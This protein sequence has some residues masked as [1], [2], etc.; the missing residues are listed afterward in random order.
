MIDKLHFIS[1]QNETINHLQSICKALMCGCKWVQ[2]RVKKEPENIIIDLA[3]EA[4]KLCD[5]FQAKLIINDYP[6][7][8]KEVSAH[9]VH[10][11]SEDMSIAEARKI[12]GKEFIIGGTSN[13]YEKIVEH[14]NNG[15]DYIGL[16]P[17]RFTK[18][19]ENLS[20]VL[21]TEGYRIII[22]RLAN[23]NINI[24]V[25]AIGGIIESD[26]DALIDTGVY[27]IAVSSLIINERKKSELVRRL[28][29]SLSIHEFQV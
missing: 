26:L 6:L 14:V 9:G 19:K 12:T 23:N 4:K 24:P 1:Q 29:S 5:Q 25:I 10:L 28:H 20:P 17:L 16:G 18:T 21:G 13:T 8:A 2:L 27:G 3:I 11:G 7:I 15:A 22:E